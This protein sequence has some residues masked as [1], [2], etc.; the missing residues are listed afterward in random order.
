MS[1]IINTRISQKHDF[2]VNWNKASGFIPNAGEIIIYDAEVDA[3][4][5][6][7]TGVR[8]SSGNLPGSRTEPITTARIK[9]G[10]GRRNVIALEFASSAESSAEIVPVTQGGTGATTAAQARTNLGV[11]PA[12]IGAVPTSRTVNS[13]AL[14]SN[15]T[16]SASDVSAVPTTR[17][18]NGK[19]L[20]SDITLSAN[21]VS[22]VPTTRKVN[23][24][25]LSSNIT[26]TASDIGAA[27]AYTYGTTDLTAGV[28]PLD[29]GV[30]YF[31]YE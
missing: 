12:N 23:G 22:A 8:D 11:T 1:K 13:K 16:L 5:N 4:G 19:A 15:I 6:E 24:K 2:E 18:V 26:I 3:N 21:D 31:V 25:A 27:P 28:S 29:T 20:S 14:S 7:L 10:D 30:L 17:K 9:V